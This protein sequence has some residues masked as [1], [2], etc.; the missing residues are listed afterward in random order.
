M[1]E[2]LKAYRG[3]NKSLLQS[4]ASFKGLMSDE[5]TYV[6]DVVDT[7]KGDL[8]TN[9]KAIFATI[10]KDIDYVKTLETPDYIHGDSLLDAYKLTLIM[11][12]NAQQETVRSE[13]VKE[14]WEDFFKWYEQ[15]VSAVFLIHSLLVV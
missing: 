5:I 9:I 11:S 10:R 15:G 12:C 14:H 3:V 8:E 1:T 4:F 6:G 13:Y 2:E 7:D